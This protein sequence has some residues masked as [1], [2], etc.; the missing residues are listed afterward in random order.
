MRSDYYKTKCLEK[1]VILALLLVWV[2]F[3]LM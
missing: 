3:A 2:L 1:L